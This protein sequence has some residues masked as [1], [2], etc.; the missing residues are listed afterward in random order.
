MNSNRKANWS[1]G[2]LSGMIT[3]FLLQ[4]FD[5]LKTY[6]IAST[7]KNSGMIKGYKLVSSRFG[8]LGMWRGVDAAVSRAMLGSGS[9][10][11]LLEEFKQILGPKSIIS[12]GIS[13]GL[14]KACVTIICQPISIIKVR[15]E[16]PNYN[17]YTGL[18]NGISKIYSSE[19]IRGFYIGLV[20][21]IIKDVPY[22]TIGMGFYEHYIKVMMNLTNLDRSS[23]IVTLVSGV[24][25][26]FTATIITHPFDVIKTRIQLARLNKNECSRIYSIV[27]SIYSIDGLIG[28]Q[29]GLAPRLARRVFSFPLVWT[30]YEQIKMTY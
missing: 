12:C 8:M 1:S 2:C 7:Q 26:G 20:P 11:L 14:A 18:F 3:A 19:G 22:S 24:C 30:L 21:S 29:R 13:S 4:P 27:R 10:F 9:Y 25:A 6:S 15:I 5:V 28:F 16:C 17:S 23:A